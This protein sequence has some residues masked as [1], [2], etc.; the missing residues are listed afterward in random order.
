M[1]KS[2]ILTAL[3]DDVLSKYR[4]DQEQVYLTGTSLGGNGTWYLAC[5][6]PEYFAAIAPL[7]SNPVIPDNWNKQ[8]LSMPIWAFHGENDPILPLKNAEAM[9]TALRKQGGSPRFTVLPDQGHYI[10]GVYK[11]NE[12]YDWFLAN[13]LY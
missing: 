12:L 11:N 9:I 1:D 2:D 13:S 3:L 6:H 5:Q 8:L 10:A 7:A 4:I